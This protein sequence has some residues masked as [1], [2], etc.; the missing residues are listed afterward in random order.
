MKYLCTMKRDELTLAFSRLGRLMET[1]S[2]TD[3]WPGFSTG[4][5]EQEWG[6][7]KAV[8]N[9]QFIYNG[10]FTK[11]C[12]AQS[13]SA[14]G[15]Q[16]TEERLATWLE[17]YEYS[18]TPKRV[19]IIMAGN[20]PLVGFHDFL[21]VLFSGN[22]AVCKL[23]SEDKTLL[24]ALA[25]PLITFLPELKDRIE[26]TV[27]PVKNIDAVIATGSDNSALYFE[28]YFGKYPHVFRKNRTSIA[29]LTGNETL[30]ELKGLGHDIFDYYGLGCRNVS[31]IMIPKHYELSTFFE[32][33]YS[34]SEVV[35][36]KKYGNNYDYHKA[37]FLMNQHQLFDNNF[38]LLRETQELFSPLAM[39]HFQHYESQE[40]VDHFLISHTE[41]IQVVIG[42][43][44]TPFGSAQCPL[45]SDYAD[46]VDT[47]T[48]LNGL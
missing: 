15:S 1:L 40:E 19:A 33:I 7:L 12:V 31:H 26:F 45:L 32:G 29:V 13:L 3:E 9:R 27:G 11:E 42:H 14:L 36:N 37:I 46:G 10:W 5:T 35:L 17:N 41:S 25:V 39:V 38:V 44:Y 8:I 48:F 43:K 30:E 20:I 23:S 6:T 18:E 24:P 34:F 16:L 28:Q 21:C 22:T 47:M 2:Y 4:V